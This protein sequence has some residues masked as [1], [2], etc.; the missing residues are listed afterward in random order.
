MEFDPFGLSVKDLATRTLLARCDSPGPLYTLRLPASPTS[1]SAPPVLAAASSSVTCHRRL[2]HPGCDVM[3][4]LS[5]STSISGCR[6]SF[7]HLCHACQLGRHVR[8][9]FLTSSRAAVTFDLIHCD[10]WTSP[11]ISISGYQYYL[12]V[13]DDFSHYLWTFPLRQ[14][15]DTFPT[16][17]HFFAWVSTQFGDTIWSIQCDN[18]REF[19]NNV[20][21]DIFLSRGV[22]L[23]MSCPYT[24]P[25][26]GR[27]ERMIR[28][29][30]DVLRSLLFQASLPAPYWAEALTTA[31]YLLNRLPTKAVAHPTPYFALFDIHPSYDHL[32]VFRCACY[33]NLASTTPHKLAPRST[34]CVFFGYSPNHKG[35]RCLDLTSHRVLIS[36]Y[37]IFDES[38][39]PFSSSSSTASHRARRVPRSR[40][41]VSHYSPPYPAGSFTAPP[42]V[43]SPTTLSPASPRAA[44]ASPASPRA[45]HSRYPP[46]HNHVRPQ[47]PLRHLARP[48]R[49]CPPPHSHV[50]PRCLQH[51]PDRPCRLATPTPSRRTS[52]VVVA[53]PRLALA[54]TP[55]LSPRHRPPGSSPHPPDGHPARGGCPPGP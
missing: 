33:P 44:S 27:A 43:A 45:P 14:K 4:K 26:N 1:T 35:Y 37:V 50:R 6:G 13:L 21:R 18:G 32:R 53:V 51:R 29:M 15:S 17:S 16:L 41:C 34:R 23:R 25:Q 19:Y 48:H 7:E 3:S 46:P 31:T 2:G 10:V 11:A 24:S 28:T 39:F 36:H 9:P 52:A 47:R 38:D 20:S 12:L 30:N 42:R 55:G 54:P 40:P 5:S 22:H 8:F 49:R